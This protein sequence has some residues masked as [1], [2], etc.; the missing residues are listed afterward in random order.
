MATANAAS[1]T[2]EKDLYCMEHSGKAP[3]FYLVRTG[4][5]LAFWAIA[6][7]ARAPNTASRRTRRLALV[8]LYVVPLGA[9]QVVLAIEVLRFQGCTAPEKVA[10]PSV[11]VESPREKREP[12]STMHG[13][14]AHIR[15][16]G[17]HFRTGWSLRC[18]RGRLSLVAASRVGVH[19]RLDGR[20]RSG[21][22]GRHCS[23][24]NQTAPNA[25]SESHV[26]YWSHRDMR[27]VR[28]ML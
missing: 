8:H 16:H 19:S 18:G 21:R 7:S 13:L 20:C 3:S 9:D 22:R 17:K 24:V 26:I 4:V 1:W 2:F 10:F 12:T 6:R 5:L 25:R 23:A 14:E 28:T 11:T 15:L 27:P